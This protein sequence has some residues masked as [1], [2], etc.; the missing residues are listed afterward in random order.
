VLKPLLLSLLVTACNGHQLPQ[1]PQQI[2]PELDMSAERLDDPELAPL[3]YEEFAAY[4]TTLLHAAS[5]STYSSSSMS[6]SPFS[7]SG[8]AVT[9]LSGQRA[10]K[11]KLNVLLFDQFKLLCVWKCA[12]KCVTHRCAL[13][14]LLLVF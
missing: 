5:H 12:M 6:S 14:V 11:S 2:I 9:P 7:G 3:T 10:G 4:T 13:P 1:L 8:T